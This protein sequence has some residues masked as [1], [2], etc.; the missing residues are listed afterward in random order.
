MNEEMTTRKE[1]KMLIRERGK[2]FQML[3][4]GGTHNSLEEWHKLLDYY[5][6]WS[7]CEISE[8]IRMSAIKGSK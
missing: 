5:D 3:P 8:A 4:P 7:M 1:T 2:L 6:E